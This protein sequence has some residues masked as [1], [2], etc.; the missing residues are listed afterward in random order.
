MTREVRGVAAAPGVALAAVKWLAAAPVTSPDDTPGSDVDVEI[1]RAE[2]AFETVAG[3]Y[4]AQA[5]EATG[6]AADILFMTSALAADPALLDQVRVGIR[7]GGPTAHSV[8]EA[9]AHFAEQLA[10]LGGMMAERASDLRDV[11]QRVVAEL[12]GVDPPGIP[13]SATPFVLAA[14]DLA[15]AD[16][17]TLDPAR[18]VGLLTVAGG[19]TSHTAILAKAL[20][21]PAVV[22]CP[23]A[24]EIAEGTEVVLDG[25]SGTVEIAPD[26]KRREEVLALRAR[27][28]D[29]PSGPGR[30]AD[31]HAV[32]LLANVGSVAD[33]RLAVELGAEGVGLF[34]TEFLFLGRNSAPSIEDQTQQYAEIFAA[35]GDRPITV[36]TLDAGS[37]KPLPFL[38]LPDEE[39]PALGVRGLRLRNVHEGTLLDQLT[40]IRLAQQ[41]TGATVKV[42]AP[43]VATVEEARYF[44]AKAR[45]AGLDTRG[46]MVEIPAA[47]IRSA[48]LGA[49]V[50][51]FSIGTNDLSQYLF[52]A[53]RMSSSLA[54]LHDPWQPALAATI[55][56]VVHGATANGV[57]VGVCGE[58]ASH[59]EFACVLVGLGVETLSMAPRSLAG[60]RAALAGVTLA[61][62]RAAADA[63]L[64]AGTAEEAARAARTALGRAS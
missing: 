23:G 12:L 53:D 1:A 18:V 17:V 62:C 2:A 29:A 7:A 44:A 28:A 45:E 24:V 35:L 16:T 63:V 10:A 38:N 15:P 58:S 47:A 48:Y 64:T 59:P 27:Q 56:A 51:F 26:A 14:Q 49:E 13:E 34:R 6:P 19:P 60:V 4:A 43:M 3:R 40:A 42:M 54:A 37:D 21:I 41:S 5:S 25:T 36:R 46:I 61:Q 8:T 11:G 20:G 32:P 22:A 39:N 55:A 52:G 30:T 50:D 57:K 33:A 9:V 31:G